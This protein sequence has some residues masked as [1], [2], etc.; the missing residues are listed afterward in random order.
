VRAAPHSVVS[1]SRSRRPGWTRRSEAVSCR[2][3]HGSEPIV[4]WS[5]VADE[6]LN[7]YPELIRRAAEAPWWTPRSPPAHAGTR[8]ASVAVFKVALNRRVGRRGLL[9]AI[10]GTR[11]TRAGHADLPAARCRSWCEAALS[12]RLTGAPSSRGPLVVQASRAVGGHNN[13]GSNLLIDE[14]CQLRSFSA[15]E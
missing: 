15:P 10:P 2:P 7:T 4:V 14:A 12:S 5:F 13:A 6:V 9:A 8:S 3:A 11:S 1:T